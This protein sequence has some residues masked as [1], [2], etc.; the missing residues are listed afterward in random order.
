M[1]G[2]SNQENITHRL[3]ERTT[4]EEIDYLLYKIDGKQLFEN[5]ETDTNK[6]ISGV[7]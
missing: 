6:R 7:L 4:T 3:W 1:G 2:N 5:K